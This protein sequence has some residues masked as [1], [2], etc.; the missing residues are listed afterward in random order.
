MDGQVVYENITRSS[1]RCCSLSVSRNAHTVR[2]LG[3]LPASSS[4]RKRMNEGR[5]LTW[6]CRRSSDRWFRR[7]RIRSLNRRSRQVG[8]RPAALFRSVRSMRARMGRNIPQSMALA[9]ASLGL[10]RNCVEPFQRVAC[11]RKAGVTVLKVKE[12]ILHKTYC[13]IFCLYSVKNLNPANAKNLQGFIEVAITN[14]N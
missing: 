9:V 13:R 1:T 12:A 5:S 8:L 3:T 10:P 4:P 2:A 11:F 6:Y 14:K 7:R